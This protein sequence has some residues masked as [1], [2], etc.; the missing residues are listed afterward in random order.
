[1]AVLTISRSYQSGGHEIGRAVARQTGYTFVDKGRIYA[2]MKALGEKWGRLFEETDEASPTL[3]EKND[4]QYRG[5]I[6]QIESIILD[7]ALKDRAVI[8]GRGG[9]FILADIPHILKVRLD[10][11]LEVRV[12]RAIIKNET[13]RETAEALI[14]KTDNDRAG[15]VR[16]IYKKDW[17]DPRYYDRIID[18]S[19][20][21]QEEIVQRLVTA[22]QE[23]EGRA[24]EEGRKKLAGRAVAAKI[25]ARIFGH[26]KIFVPTLEVFHEGDDIVLR[27]VI[28][29]PQERHEIEK[30][31][32]EAGGA[33]GVRNELRNRT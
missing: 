5:F 25:K 32:E 28:H 24:T 18:T 22:L 17:G 11:P 10:A 29:S 4:W 21:T 30:I 15:Y 3:W 2:E 20:Y 16:S 7:Y 6:A 1:M 13:P 8:L 27:G 14:K 33:F 19:E 12:Q 9:N 23:W 26:P 31:I